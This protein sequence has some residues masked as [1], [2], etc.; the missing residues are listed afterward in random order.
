M[1]TLEVLEVLQKEAIETNDKILIN[2]IDVLMATTRFLCDV[3]PIL[4][5]IKHIHL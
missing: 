3:S 5:L 2:Y 4:E 1:K